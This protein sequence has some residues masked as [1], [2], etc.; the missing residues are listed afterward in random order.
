[1]K[2]FFV[3]LAVSIALAVLGIVPLLGLPG[4]LPL[5]VAD[6][7]LHGVKGTGTLTRFGDSAWAAAIVVTLLAPVPIAPVLALVTW[8]RPALQVGLAWVLAFGVAALWALGVAFV[9]LLAS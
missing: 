9:V 4:V 2:R 5:G 3:G 1:V 7:I 8:R 6:M